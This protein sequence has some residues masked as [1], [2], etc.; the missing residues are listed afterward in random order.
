[1]IRIYL[2]LSALLLLV[3][4]SIDE[5][6]SEETWLQSSS[7]ITSASISNDGQFALIS[8]YDE[9]AGWWDLTKNARL[10]NWRHSSDQQSSQDRSQIQFTSISPDLTRALTATD[11]DLVIW[12]TQSGKATGFYQSPTD[13]RAISISNQGQY[14]L[15]ALSDGRAVTISMRNNR[16]MEFLGHQENVLNQGIPRNYIGINTGDISANGRYALTGGDDHFA[17]L[18]DTKT[19]QIVHQWQHKSRVTTVRLS[20]D[21]RFAFSAGNKAEAYIWDIVT[22][23][24]ISRLRL[25]LREYIITSARFSA[26]NQWL[27][28][29]APG[30]NLTLW[31]VSDGVARSK[32]KVKKR[33]KNRAS[34]AVVLDTAFTKDGKH[35]LTEASSGYGQKWLI[36]A[37]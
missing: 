10:Y 1:M 25:K 20:A 32:W 12:D 8:G 26:D 17:I 27:A 34:G 19:G 4:C 5:P 24:Q 21:G 35:L 11:R 7:G 37:K 13:I 14:V 36:P 2:M 9:P 31:Q 3:A 18:W 29:G 15:L 22:G 6:L 30:R 23:K 16:R 28:T 33:H